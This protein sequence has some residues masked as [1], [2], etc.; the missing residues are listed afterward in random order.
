MNGMER[1]ILHGFRVTPNGMPIS[2][3]FFTDDSVLFGNAT[4]EEA[5]GVV[6]VLKTYAY[7]SG[8]GINMAKSSIFFGSKITK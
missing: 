5:Q 2:H 8:Q 7:G 4:V 1:E 3:L 6:D